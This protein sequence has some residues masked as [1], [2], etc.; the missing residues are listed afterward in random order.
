[1]MAL[2]LFHEGFLGK[3]FDFVTFP[4]IL[5]DL[6]SSIEL[7]AIFLQY[8]GVSKNRGTPKWMVCNGKPH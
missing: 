6:Y 3:G 4:N 7:P 8:M 1:M 5:R 2:F